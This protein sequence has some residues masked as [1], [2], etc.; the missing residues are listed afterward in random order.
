MSRKVGWETMV[1]PEAV[2]KTALRGVG[3]GESSSR[4]LCQDNGHSG[5]LGQVRDET[6]ERRPRSR[7]TTHI[8]TE[9]Q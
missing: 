5:Y 8:N 7:A 1:S 3:N 6:A 4:L 2:S 9:L